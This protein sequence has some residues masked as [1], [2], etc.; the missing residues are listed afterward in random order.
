MRKI[1]LFLKRLADILFSGIGCLILLPLFL[2]VALIIKL[3]MPG[4][5]FFEQV[6]V[7]KDGRLFSILKFRSMKVDKEAEASH[8]DSKDAE[9]T[10]LFGKFLRRS[11]VDELPQLLNVLKGDMSMVGPRPT[12]KELADEY[13]PRQARRLTMRPGMTGWA[14]VHGNASISWDDRIEYD[15]YYV[16]HFSILLDL[17]IL[18]KTVLVVIYG[19]EKFSEEKGQTE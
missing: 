1:N 13:S 19:E 15:I 12:L 7:G 9:R 16:D 11:K 3:T 17:R 4:P 2:L 10:T 8:D 6:R 5:V 14:Q 18:L